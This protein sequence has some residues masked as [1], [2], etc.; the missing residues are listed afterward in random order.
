VKIT[1]RLAVT[2]GLVVTGVLAYGQTE[3]RAEFDVASIKLSP[4]STGRGMSVGCDGGPGTKDPGM[5]S[6]ENVTLNMLVASAYNISYDQIVA[7]DWMAQQKFEIAAKVPPGATK[8]KIEEMWQRLLADRFKMV[9]H[10]ESRI[11]AKYDLQLAKDGPKFKEAAEDPPPTNEGQPEAPRAHSTKLDQ[12]GFPELA[13]PGMIGVEG[14]ISL[15]DPKMTMERLAKTC[16]GQLGKPVTDTT[17]LTG[18]Y[19]I[20]LFWVSDSGPTPAAPDAAG[21]TLVRALQDQLGLRLEAKKGPVEFLIVDHTE[22]LP[23][24]N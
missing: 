11:V 4:P 12:N 6:C 24:E 9:V 17:G 14:R 23:T 21:P 19:E 20:R 7:P 1:R 16:T 22:R 13:R 3:T 5:I 10:R 18:Q 2:I 8:A 15:Y